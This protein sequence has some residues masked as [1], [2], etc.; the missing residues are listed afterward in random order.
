L[1]GRRPD[2]SFVRQPVPESRK[3]DVIYFAGC[4]THQTPSIKKAMKDIFSEAGTNYWFMDEAGGM[5]CG[6]PMMMA[7]HFEQ[8]SLM[9][10]KNSRVIRDSAATTLVTSCPIC[11][12]MFVQEYKLNIRVLHHTQY[13]EELSRKK[14]IRLE[15]LHTCAV[16]HDP[17]ELSRTL[18]VYEEPRKLLGNMVSLVQ[19]EYE[20]D[21]TLCCGG[22]LANLSASNEVRLKVARDAYMKI[23]PHGAQVMVTSCPMCKQAFEKVADVPVQ[24]IAE[25]VQHSM[26]KPVGKERKK[27]TQVA[28]PS[29]VLD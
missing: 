21:N 28:R 16:Y 27:G 4:M 15:P 22:S 5:C 11:Y 9:I 13:L 17:C 12:K 10:E 25:M 1:N 2:P 29:L 3:A 8:A 18:S 24:D 7:G 14:R 20:K 23:N 26:H 19:P 6:R